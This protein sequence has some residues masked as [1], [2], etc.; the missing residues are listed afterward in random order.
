MVGVVLLAVLLLWGS[1]SAR[2]YSTEGKTIRI[3]LGAYDGIREFRLGNT[4]LVAGAKE[5]G[6]L[7]EVLDVE[8]PSGFR[9]SAPVQEDRVLSQVSYPNLA[10]LE[11]ECAALEELGLVPQVFLESAGTF[12]IRLETLPGEE[13][14]DYGFEPFPELAEGI[15]LEREGGRPLVFGGAVL[16]PVFWTLDGEGGVPL[17]QLGN[18]KYRGTLEVLRSGANL[19]V[20]NVLDLEEYLYSVLPSEMPASWPLEALKAQAVAARNYAVYYTEV[21]RKYP[22]RPFDLDDSTTSQVYLGYGNEHPNARRA[23][24][25][26]MNKLLY[27]ENAVIIA[28]YFSSSGGHTEHS[29]NVWSASVPYLRGVP[30]LYDLYTLRNP[31]TVTLTYGQIREAL[32]KRDV[33]VGAVLDVQVDGVSDAGRAM[34]LKVIGEKDSHILSKETM[35]IWLGLDSRKFTIVKPEDEPRSHYA[36]VRGNGETQ[37]VAQAD[38]HIQ[39]ASGSPVPLD[40]DRG[41]LVVVG[42]TNIRNYP[43]MEGGAETVT[44]AGLGYGHGVGLSQSGA[45]GMALEGHPYD[46]ILAYYFT[47]TQVR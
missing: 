7:R 45:R 35:R 29:E 47:G 41:Q 42:A 17:L 5:G 1:V 14:A 16:E 46:E 4:R 23:V 37:I 27:Y 28:N 19:T 33:D 39:R 32:A 30:D 25:E 44:F 21:A 36:V 24:D 13:A 20:V 9:I 2:A 3:G 6:V 43:L 11:A 10:A 15:L 38:I 12:R 22:T 26:T 34:Q 8:S 31:W 18:R 40:G